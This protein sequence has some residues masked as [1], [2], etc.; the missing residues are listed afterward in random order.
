[1]G[2]GLD[3]QGRQGAVLIADLLNVTQECFSGCVLRQPPDQ[4]LLRVPQ[5]GCTGRGCLGCAGE[6][7]HGQGERCL[8]KRGG[9]GS[10]RHAAAH[11]RQA[12]QDVRDEVPRPQPE[13]RHDL[14]VEP[15]GEELPLL[16]LLLLPSR[17]PAAAP[18]AASASRGVALLGVLAE[19]AAATRAM[20]R[21][22]EGIT[23]SQPSVVAPEGTGG[24]C[25]V[26]RAAA[27]RGVS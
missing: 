17:P 14:A 6:S 25:A 12:A 9:A 19:A 23:P 7:K 22:R 26:L 15:R 2:G 16:R 8:G 24:K 10:R 11:L 13:P 5:G 4:H 20:R 3:I 27:E 1:M 21:R 18:A